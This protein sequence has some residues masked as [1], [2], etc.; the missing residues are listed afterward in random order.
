ME[1][2]EISV[3]SIQD[4]NQRLDV[5]IEILR[6]AQNSLSA[7]PEHMAA[8]L[9]EVLR[10]GE[11]MRVGL[12]RNAEGCMADELERYRLRLEQLRHLLPTLH[13]Q[14]LTERSLLQAEKNHLEATAAWSRSAQGQSR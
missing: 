4:T 11:W 6:P 13:A 14:L 7:T 2:V 3:Q 12:A 9:A 8:V 10:A 5:L 1:G